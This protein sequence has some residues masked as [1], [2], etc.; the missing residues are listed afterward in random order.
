ML[1]KYLALNDTGTDQL[2]YFKSSEKEKFKIDFS[3]YFE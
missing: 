3:C 2:V 1:V